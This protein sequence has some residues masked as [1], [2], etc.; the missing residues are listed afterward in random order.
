MSFDQSVIR[1]AIAQRQV[2]EIEDRLQVGGEG[3]KG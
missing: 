1:P 3:V 2:K